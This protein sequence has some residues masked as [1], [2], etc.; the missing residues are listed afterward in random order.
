MHHEVLTGNVP[1]EG[2]RPS[3]GGSREPGVMVC[4]ALA[5][6]E[7]GV[8]RGADVRVLGAPVRH[9]LSQQWLGG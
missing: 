9:L 2:R 6:M 5:L 3:D 1:L 8:G 4:V 7:G